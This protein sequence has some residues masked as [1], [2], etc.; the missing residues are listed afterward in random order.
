MTKTLR[1]L[2][3]AFL[4]AIGAALAWLGLELVRLGGSPYYLVGGGVI[5]LSTWLIARRNWRGVWLY[6]AFLLATLL[7]ALW[8]S[9]LGGWAL[10]PRLGLP[11]AVG[12]WMLT[13]LFRRGMGVTTPLPAGRILWPVLCAVALLAIGYTF[14]LDRASG[15]HEMATTATPAYPGAGEWQHYGNDAGGS[16]YSTLAQITPANVG[17]LEPAWT[18]HIGA[19]PK[20][21]PVSFQANPLM[22]DGRVFICTGWSDVIALDA[23][24]GKQLWRHYTRADSNGALNRSCRG[25]TYYRVPG[26]S[27][28]CAERIYTPTIDARLIALDARSGKP[29]PG[30]GSGGVVDLTQGMGTFD[31]GYY[32]ATSPPMLIRGKLVLGGWVTDGQMV[33][34][35]SGVIRAYDAVTGAFAWAFDIGRPDFHD[36]PAKGQTFTRGTPN[37]WAPMSADETLGLVYLPTGNAT[38]DYV[39]M[40]RTPNDDRF[41]SS[42][43]A[44]DAETGALRWSFQTTHHDLWDYDVGSQPTLVD[45]P[46]GT[47]ALIQPTKRGEIFVLDRRTGKPVMPVVERPVPQG[48][49]PGERLAKTQPFSV[50]LPSFGGPAPTER[51]MWGLTPIDQAMCRIRFRKARFEGTMTPLGLDRPTITWPGYLGGMDWGGVAIDKQRQLMIVNNNQIANYNQLIRRADADKMGIKPITSQSMRNAGGAAA[52]KGTPYAALSAPFL[53]PLAVPCQQPPYGRISAVDLRT[54]KL[55]WSE[56][57]GTSRDSG[58]LLMRT[59]IPIPMGVPNLGGAVA[60]AGGVT[61][62][63]ATQERMVRAYNS[64]TGAELWKA[65]LPAGGQAAPTVYW[66]AKSNREF[67]VIAAGGHAAML[68]GSSDLLTAY[69]LPKSK[70]R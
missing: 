2:F 57:L 36:M 58:P 50:G 16:R 22:V 12:L 6:G 28:D 69:A 3:I 15:G 14:W 30:F 19:P 49:V 27:N 33:G 7:W 47:P 4:A 61:F 55:I 66:S 48:A 31:K 39:G 43:V 67:M 38:P 40:H 64:Q 46:N 21:M 9:G 68:S 59:L 53:S 65:A 51:T 25:V 8:E 45:L 26:A 18:Y 34:E 62:I 44:L 60:T 11:L 32:Y 10:A 41:S 1:L 29:C 23:E 56:R 17:G 52:Q 20:G 70:L 42:V 5:L 37:S 13:P 54:G 63:A 35:P 24:T